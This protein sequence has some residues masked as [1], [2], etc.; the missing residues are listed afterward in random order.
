MDNLNPITI[1]AIVQVDLDKAWHFW[2]TP[3]HIINWNFAV[4]TWHCP[5]AENDLKVGGIFTYTMAAKDGSFSF[6]FSGQYEEIIPGKKLFFRLGDDRTVE[7]NFSFDQQGTKITETFDPESQ[8]PIE[9]QRAGWQ[10]ILDN[11][12][13]YVEE[14]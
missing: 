9:M 6:D 12:K 4:D 10:A 1:E 2:T 3:E 14:I 8:N 5:K 13:R 7:V 11:F